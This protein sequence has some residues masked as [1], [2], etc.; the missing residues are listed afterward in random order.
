MISICIPYYSKM[1][2]AD[3]FLKRCIES[4]EK[5]TYKNVEI[6]VTDEGNAPHNTNL[7]I[8]KAK[9]EIIKILFMDD[10]LTHDNVLQEIIDNFK[11][12]WLV[13]GSDNNQYPYY[14]GDIHQGNNK[15]GSPS[16]LTIRQGTE[17][18]FDENLV[19]LFD[20]DYYKRMYK[21]YGEPV[22]IKGNHI[23]QGIGEHQATNNISKEIKGREF[24]LMKEK[25]DNN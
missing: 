12:Q 24:Y 6:V 16:A 11:G 1:T 14:T 5:Q 9:G 22:I 20:C 15:L 19:W 2:N 3:F 23:T 18:T 13:S 21:L 7:A 17:I 8:S 10:Y 4:I 25:Y